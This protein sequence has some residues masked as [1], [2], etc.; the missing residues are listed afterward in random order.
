MLLN[1]LQPGL[2]TLTCPTCFTWEVLQCRRALVAANS[3]QRG[4]AGSVPYS[5]VGISFSSHKQHD[6]VAL[7]VLY[8]LVTLMKRPKIVKREVRKKEAEQKSIAKAFKLSYNIPQ[9]F[10]THSGMLLYT[11]NYISNFTTSQREPG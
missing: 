11:C 8:S 9:V 7:H 6:I 4:C 1:L 2:I 5:I 10:Q 3:S